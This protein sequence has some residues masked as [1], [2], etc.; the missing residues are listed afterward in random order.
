MLPVDQDGSLDLVQLENSIDDDTCIVSVMWAN[1]ET[2]VIFPIEKISEI[3]KSRGVL[4]H[5]DAVQAAG[6]I[7]I[8]LGDVG[9][10]FFR[11]LVTRFMHPRGSV[12]YLSVVEFL[13]HR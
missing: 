3:V 9:I 2:G 1:N 10:D 5:C 13:L 6:K 7:P 4:F 8:N 11:Y 12:L